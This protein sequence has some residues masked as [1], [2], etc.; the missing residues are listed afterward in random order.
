[1]VNW[2][3]PFAYV[4]CGVAHSTKSE[5]D[6]FFC[7][8]FSSSLSSVRSIDMLW[9]GFRWVT[10]YNKIAHLGYSVSSSDARIPNAVYSLPTPFI[11]SISIGFFK[12]Y[13]VANKLFDWSALA[14]NRVRPYKINFQLYWTYSWLDWCSFYYEILNSIL[15]HEPQIVDK[16]I[17]GAKKSI[18]FTTGHACKIQP[19]RKYSFFYFCFFYYFSA[20]QVE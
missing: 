8:F 10:N 12:T 13:T 11:S 6:S 17:A 19:I 18:Q 14:M 4:P 3:M 9:C 1:M 20:L 2:W 16:M 15:A 7:R 5:M